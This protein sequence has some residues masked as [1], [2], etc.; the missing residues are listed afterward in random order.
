[1]KFFFRFLVLIC[2]V[3]IGM[4]F[5]A[6]SSALD[7]LE[8]PNS[9]YKISTGA[10]E[11]GDTLSIMT[12][13]IG[14]LSGMTNN[15]SVERTSSL[16]DTHAAALLQCLK[17][18]AVDILAMQEIDFA[19]SRSYDVD[20]LDLIARQGGFNYAAKALNW[21]KR[22]VPFPYWP[23]KH[24][25]GKVQSGQAIVSKFKI[26]NHTIDTL[27]KPLDQPF[28]Y[29]DFYLDRLV[30]TSV[31]YVNKKPLTVMNVH[32]EAFSRKTR[33]IQLRYVFEKFRT[34]A[35]TSPT[36]LLGDFNEPFFPQEHSYMSPFY[37]SS[38][39]GQAISPQE[40]QVYPE[41]HFTYSAETP[42][43]KIDYIFYSKAH[44]EM[45]SAETL[46][47]TQLLSDH[48]PVLMKFRLK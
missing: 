15:K 6:T 35:I 7:P 48:L 21:D 17:S 42:K 18:S 20:Q 34:S 38:I 36:I 29:N 13:N 28:Y 47:T 31:I 2:V 12:F 10:E 39:I 26:H 30:Q 1:M 40:L 45:V 5:W 16:F 11:Q 44:I 43:A 22:Y 25:F 23:F 41:K 37:N 4:Y 8:K 46:R 14:Y 32:L 3:V 19:S 33:S 27:P 24:H 9:I